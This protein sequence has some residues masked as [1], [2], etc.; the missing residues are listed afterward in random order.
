MRLFITQSMTFLTAGVACLPDSTSAL[1]SSSLVV[2]MFS[3]SEL[4]FAS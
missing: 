4:L 3:I 1:Y 2:M